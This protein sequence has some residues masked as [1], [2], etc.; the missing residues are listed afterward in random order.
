MRI[1]YSPL[2]NSSIDST[3]IDRVPILDLFHYKIGYL[4]VSIDDY[5]I[6]SIVI[7]QRVRP[8]RGYLAIYPLTLFEL[9]C[10]IYQFN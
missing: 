5:L 6:G 7:H 1:K 4:A 9:S 8:E 3:E 2:L 10:L